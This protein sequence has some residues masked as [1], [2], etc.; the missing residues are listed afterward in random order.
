LMI[1]SELI[2]THR[3]STFCKTANYRVN[4]NAGSVNYQRPER[5]GSIF[6][7]FKKWFRNIHYN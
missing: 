7:Q 1:L 3:K 2:V 4:L 6:T 5:K